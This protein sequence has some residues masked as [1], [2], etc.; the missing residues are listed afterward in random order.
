MASV[1][2]GGYHPNLMHPLLLG[3][4]SVLHL[5]R[6]KRNVEETTIMKI[7]GFK[8]FLIGMGITLSA[9]GLLCVFYPEFA[10]KSFFLA[11]QPNGFYEA[12]KLFPKNILTTVL[13]VMGI[14]GF[15][16]ILLSLFLDAIGK[17][18][19]EEWQ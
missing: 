13:S 3:T 19:I 5:R 14:S 10:W 8:L 7:T 9:G 4:G 16:I 12:G 15:V 18:P 17:L 6:I 2:N 11:F 1:I